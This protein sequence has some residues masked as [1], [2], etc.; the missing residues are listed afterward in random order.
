MSTNNLRH[1]FASGGLLVE[2]DL[3]MI[4][5]L[6]GTPRF[7]PPPAMPISRTIPSSP[8]PTALPPE[9]QRSPGNS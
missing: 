5:K 2:E 4:G 1:S 9:S 3:P 8:L 7:K 6:L